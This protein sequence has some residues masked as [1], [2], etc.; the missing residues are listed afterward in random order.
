MF[1]YICDLRKSPPPP[2]L[3]PPPPSPPPP[4]FAPGFTCP[5][6][7][8]GYFQTINGAQ[9]Y[10]PRCPCGVRLCS[11]G[12]RK[13]SAADAA[14]TSMKLAAL[15]PQCLKKTLTFCA[16][17]G[18]R[19]S[20]GDGEDYVEPGCSRFYGEDRKKMK[21]KTVTR[22]SATTFSGSDMPTSP[23][24]KRSFSMT[25]GASSLSAAEGDVAMAVAELFESDLSSI[26]KPSRMTGDYKSSIIS[27]TP[28]GQT[29]DACVDIEAGACTRS[30]FSST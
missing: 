14:A 22:G 10:D 6:K 5:F 13:S 11:A 23:N 4:Y 26:S 19:V 21:T 30:L 28:H 16:D 27:L 3:S 9:V 25:V 17:R 2:P 8:T 12:N 18:S 20:Q 7:C 24:G 15:N 29:F 1:R